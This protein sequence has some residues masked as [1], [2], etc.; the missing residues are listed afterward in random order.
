M[1]LKLQPAVLGMAIALGL[2]ACG[3]NDNATDSSASTS[4]GASSS[5]GSASAVSKNPSL[6]DGP[7]VCFRAIEQH[8]GKDAKVSE[9]TSF[10]SAGSDIEGNDN[11]PQ[12]EMT[13]CTVQ[14][15]NPEDPRKLLET[16]L[17]IGTG[18]FGAPDQIEI[19]VTGGDAASFKLDDYLVP[20]SSINAAALS[21]AMKAQDARM[22]GIYGKHAW[23]GVRLMSPGAFSDTHLLRLDIVG[24]LASNDVKQNGYATY[25][26]DGT[27]IARDHLTP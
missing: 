6:A 9:I 13:L 4:A 5:S 2:S 19:S 22:A 1:K 16:R 17:D 21:E 26:L 24:R 15:Q 11:A 14:Y 27:T 12:G 25:A 7:D 23:S 8:L 20:L 3:S 10:F 18:K